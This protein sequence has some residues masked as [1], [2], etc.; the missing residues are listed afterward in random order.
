[1]RQDK[2]DH[3]CLNHSISYSSSYNDDVSKS[4]IFDVSNSEVN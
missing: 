3:E 2:F 4:K 1:M